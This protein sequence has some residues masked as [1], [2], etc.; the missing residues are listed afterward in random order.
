MN[1]NKAA[2]QTVEGF[3]ENKLPFA[4]YASLAAV[5]GPVLFA[6]S[7]LVIG[8]LRPVTKT[9]YGLIGGFSGAVSNP[10]SA[11]GVGPHAGLF[12]CAFV[13]C[14]LLTA[15]GVFG[16]FEATRC[17]YPIA[18]RNWCPVLLALSP[19]GLALA[20][21]FTLVSSLGMHNLAALLIFVAPLVAFPVSARHFRRIAHWRRYGTFLLAGGPITLVLLVLFVSSFHLSAIVAGTGTAGLTE[22]LLLT[23]IHLWYVALGWHAFRL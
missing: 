21:V 15:V 16:A 19:I 20:G 13:L 17:T 8:N 1:T 23:E 10:I 9:E 7:W 6:M 4:R 22:R 12:N 5:V 18:S 2:V 14:G 11:L 3:Q